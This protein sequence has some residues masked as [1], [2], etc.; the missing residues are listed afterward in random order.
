MSGDRVAAAPISWG[1]CEVPGWGV[2]LEPERVLEEMRA[3]GLTATEAGPEGF[4]P[5]DPRAAAAL[6][7]RSGMQLV[8]AFVPAALHLD[9]ALEPIRRAAALLAEAGARALVLAATTG[10]DGYDADAALDDAAWERLLRGLDEARTVCAV[11]GVRCSLHP[12]A[13]TVVERR[14]H[15]ERVLAGSTVELCLDTGHLMVGGADPLAIAQ[16][17]ASRIGHVHLKDVDA[18]MAARVA[19]GSLPYSQAV[20]DG[21]YRPLGAGDVDVAGIVSLLEGAGYRG[22]YVLEQDVMLDAEPPAGAGP[23]G[24]VRASAEHLRSL[25]ADNGAAAA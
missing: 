6:L 4:L 22:W 21:M 10:S 9:G 19:D 25:L 12:H 15:V 11:E 24:D 20:R 1:V 7:E 16:A 18:A 23:L 17:A 8:G 3:L 13:G 2:Q 5:T 14:E